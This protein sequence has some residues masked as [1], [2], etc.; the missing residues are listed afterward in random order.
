M[1]DLIFSVKISSCTE[2]AFYIGYLLSKIEQRLGSP[3]KPLSSLGALSYKNYW[4]LA[5]MR[6]LR[7]TPENVPVRLQGTYM[8]SLLL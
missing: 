7:S 1:V 3:E 4:T 2:N 5:I 6:F 8:G